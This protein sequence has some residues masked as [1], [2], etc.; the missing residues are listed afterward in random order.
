MKEDDIGPSQNVNLKYDEH[1][2]F[3]KFY[4]L[5][6]VSALSEIDSQAHVD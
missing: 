2:N 1:H 3:M 6:D 4:Y 5:C